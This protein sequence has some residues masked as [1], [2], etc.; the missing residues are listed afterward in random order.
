MIDIRIIIGLSALLLIILTVKY[1]RMKKQIRYL[2]GQINDLA[3]GVS[4]KMLDM[5]L[6]DRDLEKLSGA[7]NKHYAKQR[8]T[9]A[10][11]LIHI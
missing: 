8:Y 11:S 9:V 10:L 5:S 3:D 4:E 6:V 1:I 2:T 7:I